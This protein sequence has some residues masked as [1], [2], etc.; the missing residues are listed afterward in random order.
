VGSN[1]E[2]GG[3]KHPA[4]PTFARREWRKAKEKHPRC[5]G[6]NAGPPSRYFLVRF[7]DLAASSSMRPS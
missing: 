6:V 1:G 7:L 3:K 2:L 4:S 5:G